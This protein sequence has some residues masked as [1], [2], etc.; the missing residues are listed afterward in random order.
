MNSANDDN[1][2]AHRLLRKLDGLKQVHWDE[3]RAT[4]RSRPQKR[5]A[6]IGLT[7]RGKGTKIMLMVDAVGTPLSAFTYGANVAEVNAIETR[8]D[9]SVTGRV[10]NRLLYDKAADAD[11]LRDHLDDRS[12]E[13]ICTPL[14]SQQAQRQDGRALRR[15][16]KRFVVE[17]TISWL[18]NLRRLIVRWEYN[19]H[20]FEGFLKLACLFTILKWF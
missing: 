19:N 8:V 12:V 6:E 14:Q 10:P 2:I 11:W 17:R 5:G 7:K 9:L 16:W 20:L 18:H 1:P 15:Y 13:L 3:A 4:A